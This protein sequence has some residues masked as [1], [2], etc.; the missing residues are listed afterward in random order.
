MQKW[1]PRTQN[2]KLPFLFSYSVNADVF[3][4]MLTALK[5]QFMGKVKVIFK[6][7]TG[8]K[9]VEEKNQLFKIL[10]VKSEDEIMLKYWLTTL[11]T[12]YRSHLNEG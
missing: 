11:S 10:Q 4:T 8:Q 12:S 6:F 9:S 5:E 1:T 7:K 3:E 2:F